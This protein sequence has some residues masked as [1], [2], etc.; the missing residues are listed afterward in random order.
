MRMLSCVPGLGRAKGLAQLPG[1]GRIEFDAFDPYW[2]PFLWGRRP[3]EPDVEL[4]LHKLADRPD[5]LFVDCGAN[6]GYWT[7]RAGTEPLG[8]TGFIAVEANPRMVRFLEK[9][10][11]R[12][13]IDCRITP[14]AVHERGGLTVLLEGA[15]HHAVAGVGATGLPV[16]T[17]TLSDLLRPVS[18]DRMTVI[19]LDVEGSEVPALKGAAGLRERNILYI[20]EDWP[21]SGMPA[22][23]YALSHGYGVF[24][25]FPN[26]APRR[27][28]S[29]ADAL[30]FNEASRTTYGPSNLVVVP[31]ERADAL[32]DRF[33]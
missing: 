12:N 13:D 30:A 25:I 23:E 31:V 19:K 21:K 24:G 22:T 28:A 32:W 33:A 20:V 8:F 4:I 11:R 3:F 6:V 27:I 7:V 10:V 17:V 1:G 16:E 26:L 2:A 29:V 15:E 14:A 9:N 18:A 5:K